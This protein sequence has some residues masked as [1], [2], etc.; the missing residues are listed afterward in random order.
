MVA[1]CDWGMSCIFSVFHSDHGVSEA[2]VYFDGTDRWVC[3]SFYLALVAWVNHGMDWYVQIAVPVILLGTVLVAVLLY[4]YQ[5]V[6]RSILFTA[7]VVVIEMAVFCAGIDLSVCYYLHEKFCLTWSAAVVV[8][9]AIIA[10]SLI[11][12]MRISRLRE[13]VRRRMHI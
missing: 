12:V 2:A 13:E 8:C 6:S 5:H 4:V 9:A 10:V 11:T 1:V 3:S 7:M